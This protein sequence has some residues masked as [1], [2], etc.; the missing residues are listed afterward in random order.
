MNKNKKIYRSH[1]RNGVLYDSMHFSEIQP[2]GKHLKY[3]WEEYRALMTEVYAK[4]LTD[5][6]VQ[7][8]R[9]HYSRRRLS[10][11]N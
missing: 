3:F 6:S 1:A 11:P 7:I 9:R 10:K 2:T 5:R 4:S 8:Y